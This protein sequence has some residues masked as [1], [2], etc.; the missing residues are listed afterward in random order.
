MTSIAAAGQIGAP[1]VFR[2]ASG[3]RPNVFDN[4][5]KSGLNPNGWRWHDLGTMPAPEDP[6]MKRLTL[7]AFVV[8]FAILAAAPPAAAQDPS[9]SAAP[10]ASVKALLERLKID[11]I[12]ARDPE[13]PGRYVA[14]LY[15]QDSQ[16]LVVSA[17]YAAPAALD[18]LIAD[19]RYMDAYINMQAVGSHQ[20][21]FFVV[22]LQA[23]GLKRVCE[24]D[25]PFDSVTIGGGTPISFDGKWDAQKLSEQQY[26]AEF[27]KADARYARMLQVLVTELAKKTTA[28]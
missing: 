22:D 11:A 5:P 6:S 17:P 7:A 28:Q 4:V 9:Q 14:A 18:K 8:L 16:L 15:V 1:P 13:A 26:D 24:P 10:A 23:D 2:Q 20:G 25:Q 27:G 21:H 19:G 3:E 12:A